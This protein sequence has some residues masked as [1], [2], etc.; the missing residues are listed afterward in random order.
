MF[1]LDPEELEFLKNEGWEKNLANTLPTDTELSP[2]EMLIGNDYYFELLQPRKIDLGNNLFAFQTKL[3]W[4]FGEKTQANMDK[5]VS[6]SVHIVGLPSVDMQVNTH[7]FTTVDSV[8]LAEPS[9]EQF[10]EP[11]S[12]GI[13]DSPLTSD[14][15]TALEKFNKSVKFTNRR[16]MVTWPWKADQPDLPENYHLALAQLKSILQKLVEVPT[17]F[18]QYDAILRE[19]LN[20]GIIEK[21][22]DE[23]VEGSEKHYIPHHPV[24]TP[25]KATTKVHVVYD[26]SAKTRPSN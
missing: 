18:V 6:S 4:V 13:T 1:S 10:W 12:L 15:D 5:V 7:V 11:E 8:L 3:G 21:V 2:V 23:L 14:D 16:Y 25:L 17:L 19:Q 20:R 9:L 26:A 22:V 24:I